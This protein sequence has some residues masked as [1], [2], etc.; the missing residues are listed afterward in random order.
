MS[1]I[2]DVLVVDDEPR[3]RERLVALVGEGFSIEEASSL[4]EA[5]SRVRKRFYYCALVDKSLIPGKG[6]DEGGMRVL[7]TLV[8]LGE[9]T[10]GLMFTAYGSVP[11]AK[12]ALKDWKATDYIEKHKLESPERRKTVRDQIREMIGE[13]RRAYDQRYGSGIVQLTADLVSGKDRAIWTSNVIGFVA[14]VGEPKGYDVLSRFLDELLREIPP[15]IPYKPGES[16]KAERTGA[17]VQ[18]TYW[19]KGL[20][21]SVIVRFGGRNKIDK[22]VGELDSESVIRHVSHG[23][24]GGLIRRTKLCFE[25]LPSEQRAS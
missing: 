10:L 14:P 24:Y 15:L 18:G 12:A 25:D 4:E 21:E 8:G 6:D 11:S 3:W 22:E 20:G 13:A 7:E 1:P 19:S 17:P 5:L 16:A 2:I 23:V 9:G